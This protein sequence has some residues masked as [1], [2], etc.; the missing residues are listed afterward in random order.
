MLRFDLKKFFRVVLGLHSGEALSVF[1]ICDYKIVVPFA[2]K[3]DIYTA[4]RIGLGCLIKVTGPGGAGLVVMLLSPRG[5]HIHDDIDV[6][7]RI[8]RRICR[9]AVG[10]VAH[11][12]NENLRLFMGK[13]QAELYEDIDQPFGDLLEI[14]GLPVIAGAR[15]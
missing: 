9:H 15:R 1:R 2:D 14:V 3:I 6:A 7:M 10:C 5:V 4:R 11:L 13:A 12:G 8:S